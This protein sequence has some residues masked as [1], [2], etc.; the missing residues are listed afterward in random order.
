MESP[1]S[2][3]SSLLS[4]YSG[5]PKIETTN[6]SPLSTLEIAK[7]SPSL[8][9]LKTTS[10]Q[11]KFYNHKEAKPNLTNSVQEF[12]KQSND[13]QTEIKKI[14]EI[15]EKISPKKEF[16]ESSEESEST[17]GILWN[18]INDMLNEYG[19]H[20]IT[21]I[22]KDEFLIPDSSSM[23]DTLVDLL[24]EF[25]SQNQLLKERSIE[26]QN[27][28]SEINELKDSQNDLENKIE[29]LKTEKTNNKL[30]DDVKELEKI[31]MQMDEKMRKFKKEQHRKDSLIRELQAKLYLKSA[32]KSI[33][34]ILNS[35]VIDKEKKVFFKMMNRDYDEKQ[36]TDIKIM[37]II[38]MYE[39]QRIMQD[40]EI[41]R[42]RLSLQD[43]RGFSKSSEN[44]S[45]LNA[46]FQ[47]SR[48]SYSIQGIF[49]RLGVQG[50]PE[51]FKEIEKLK[52]AYLASKSLEDSINKIHI[53]LFNEPF[54]MS[55]M[56]D[57]VDET[58]KALKSYKN[59]A[60]DFN[61]FKKDIAVAFG[62]EI[63]DCE[64]LI[65]KAQSLGHFRKLFQLKDDDQEF[66]A[67]EQLFLFVHEMKMFLQLARKA[68]GT[69]EKVPIKFVLEEIA[70]KILDS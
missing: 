37:A 39:Q 17:G 56:H 32:E 57:D 53:E 28:I 31:C 47:M 48:D 21:L 36:P 42:M 9:N 43:N 34:D 2:S 13:I 70:N 26:Y 30:A 8:R 4:E 65:I 58:I 27:A 33:V 7:R 44:L 20:P 40:Q 46:S 11:E 67:I 14:C 52:G 5:N 41:S 49:D 50:V 35:S 66:D 51:A 55:N 29:A 10:S 19:F 68:L 62:T 15:C 63:Y 25:T 38:L 69:N 45:F 60:R 23:A 6:K 18:E 3:T 1:Q 59:I 12:I 24:Y 64:N 54:T 16:E 22:E 61:D